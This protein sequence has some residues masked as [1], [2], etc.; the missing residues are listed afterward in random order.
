MINGVPKPSLIGFAAYKAP[1]F[2]QL[3][4]FTTRNDHLGLMRLL[5]RFQVL[6]I[7]RFQ[8][9]FFFLLSQSR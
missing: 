5:Y 8:F 9:G 1:H 3:G 4:F 6:G 2:V 7:D